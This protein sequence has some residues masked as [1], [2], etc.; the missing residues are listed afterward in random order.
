MAAVGAQPTSSHHRVNDGLA[1]R[2]QTFPPSPWN[3]M[4]D[5]CASFLATSAKSSGRPESGRS[6]QIFSHTDDRL[7]SVRLAAP[8]L[9][10]I[11]GLDAFGELA[12]DRRQKVAAFGAPALVPAEPG[13]ARGPG[14][15][16][17]AW[18]PAP[19]RCSRLVIQFRIGLGM[20]LSTIDVSSTTRDCRP[21]ARPRCAGSY[22]NWVVSRG[23]WIVL[24]YI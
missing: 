17:R 15:I 4:F 7:T 6:R 23:R 18:P 24:V 11:G 22:R 14:A 16:P 1:R 8:G 2:F 5:P 9:F 20:L 21:E 19:R 13:E 12:V 3:V 10:Q